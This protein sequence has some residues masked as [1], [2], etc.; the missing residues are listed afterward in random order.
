MKPVRAMQSR[1]RPCRRLKLKIKLGLLKYHESIVERGEAYCF[2]ADAL[3][4]AGY[5][6]EQFSV[7]LGHAKPTTTGTYGIMPQGML[8]GRIAMVNVSGLPG[9]KRLWPPPYVTDGP[10]LPC[11]T[12]LETGMFSPSLL[13]RFG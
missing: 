4:S 8:S 7:L 6:D 13:T 12:P 2:P 5:M 3:R 1:L 11:R 9:C 10:S